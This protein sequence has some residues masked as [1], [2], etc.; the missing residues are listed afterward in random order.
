MASQPEVQTGDSLYQVTRGAAAPPYTRCVSATNSLGDSLRSARSYRAFVHQLEELV[1]VAC[2]GG[3]HRIRGQVDQALDGWAA[4]ELRRLLPLN[5][6]RQIGAFFTS[7]DLS[8][9]ALAPGLDDATTDTVFV[10]PACGA[11]DLLLHVASQLPMGSSLTQ[12]L[13][14][15]SRRLRGF[16]LQPEFVEATRLRLVLMAMRRSYEL[17]MDMDA[18]TSAAF[19]GVQAG[20]GVS[21]VAEVPAVSHI[22]INPPFGHVDAPPRLAWGQGLISA[23]ALFTAAVAERASG[24]V[25]IT[26]I[27]PDVL[28]SG[29][30]YRRWRSHIESLLQVVDVEPVGRFDRWTDIDVFVLRGSKSACPQAAVAWWPEPRSSARVGDLFSVHVGTVV[31]HRDPSKGP[32]FPFIWPQRLPLSGEF[33]PKGRYRRFLGRTFEP[34]F[35]AIRRTSRPRQPNRAQGVIIRGSRRVAVENHLLVL[36]PKDRRLSTCRSLIPLLTSRAS[37]NWL[38]ERIRCRH[39]TVSAIQELPLMQDGT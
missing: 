39:V 29:S 33:D 14:L 32:W 12:T 38:D 1:G 36:L 30:R 35:I 4:V 10:D 3:L 13:A 24:G 8:R 17:G 25:S 28:R 18:Q 20:D 37:Q 23:A 16:D 7:S 15:W 19:L 11:G 5:V 26:A 21:G 2:A 31:P 22:V 27:L 34:P 9:T 6:R